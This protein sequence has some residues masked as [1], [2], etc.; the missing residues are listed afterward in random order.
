MS[1]RTFNAAS[2]LMNSG[3]YR[4]TQENLVHNLSV[5]E[6]GR[7]EQGRSVPG[8]PDPTLR[9]DCPSQEAIHKEA[10]DEGRVSR[11]HQGADARKT[12]F[13]F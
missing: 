12:L 11:R 4:D 10:V 7:N 2:V 6:Q 13:P 1:S 9:R 5:A 8:S 3:A